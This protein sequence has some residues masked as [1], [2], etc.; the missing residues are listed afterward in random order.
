MR[1]SR[2]QQVPDIRGVATA[3]AWQILTHLLPIEP[4]RVGTNFDVVTAGTHVPE[5]LEAIRCPVLAISADDD[6]FGTAIRAKY[7][8]AHVPNAKAT[9]YPTG[10]HALVG[11][12]A[13]ALR[14]AE[15]FLRSGPHP[16][17]WTVSNLSFRPLIFI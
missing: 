16:F 4:R 13:D 5:A 7:I 17:R 9:I 15:A 12:Y 11:R 2:C 1:T 14:D 6:R 8:A 3:D 10:G